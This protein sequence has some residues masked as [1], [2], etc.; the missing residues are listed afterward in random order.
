MTISHW[1]HLT[2]LG[3]DNWAL[4]IIGASNA[5]PN[6]LGNEER[7]LG[8][9]ISLKREII[10]RIVSRIK[11]EIEELYNLVETHE[12]DNV[13]SIMKDGTSFSV[14]N[15]LKYCLIAD[16]EALLFELFSCWQITKRFVLKIHQHVGNR[17]PRKQIDSEISAILSEHGHNIEWCE[18]LKDHRI[19]MAHIGGAYLAIDISRGTRENWDL[20]IMKKNIKIFDNRDEY[21]P[22]SELNG[23]FE[24][25]KFAM[26]ILQAHLIS[27][28]KASS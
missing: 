17:F 6:S 9:Y 11:D 26:N 7:E 1:I 27:L 15:D 5:T 23:I 24:D 12:N 3:G 28:F 13:S 16:I 8:T 14:D 2:D 4:R 18:L 10:R 20:I 21:I 25:F 22:F 19:F